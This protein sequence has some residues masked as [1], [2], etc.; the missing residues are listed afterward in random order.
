MS[1][2]NDFHGLGYSFLAWKL[3]CVQS[4]SLP[5]EKKI[6]N[7]ICSFQK[8][9]IRFLDVCYIIHSIKCAKCINTLILNLNFYLP[10]KI[11]IYHFKKKQ[12]KH[13]D[14]CQKRKQ[15]GS[16]IYINT[17]PKTEGLQLFVLHSILLKDTIFGKELKNKTKD[18]F[19]ELIMAGTKN[20]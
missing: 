19:P 14:W 11:I 10:L 7:K 1:V 2:A 15:I 6:M 12:R 8:Q 5:L 17:W 3:N 20:Y 4:S 13:S 16:K 9:I 18:L